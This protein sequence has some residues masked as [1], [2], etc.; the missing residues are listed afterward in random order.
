MDC[1]REIEAV[2]LKIL[3]LALVNVRGFSFTDQDV[4]RCGVEADHVHNL[5]GLIGNYS[6]SGLNYYLDV[7]I[8]EY[9]RL[10]GR[11]AGTVKMFEPLWAD[12]TVLRLPQHG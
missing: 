8:P 2:L 12:L 4:K 10:V 1:P 6:E 9:V 7:Y 11:D 3:S 5:P